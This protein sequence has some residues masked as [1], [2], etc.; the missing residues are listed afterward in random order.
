VAH[1]LK[2]TVDCL[3]RPWP[4]PRGDVERCLASVR[5]L[6]GGVASMYGP[7]PWRVLPQPARTALLK[8]HDA[9]AGLLD[10]T[11]EGAPANAGTLP[12]RAA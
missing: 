7:I 10:D 2:R 9:L 3:I 11:F 1:A 6:H 8:K 4:L 12:P 5:Y